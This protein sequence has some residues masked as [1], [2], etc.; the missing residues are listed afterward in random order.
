M[1][2][3]IVDGIL[4]LLRA[5]RHGNDGRILPKLVEIC[6]SE[7]CRTDADGLQDRR[8]RPV[9]PAFRLPIPIPTA[10]P[11]TAILESPP[12]AIGEPTYWV[13]PSFCPLAKR[14]LLLEVKL[15]NILSAGPPP[16]RRFVHIR[17]RR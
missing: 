4:L 11:G 12:N 9:R 6:I 16:S 10:V 1:T 14:W 5:K 13:N 17:I 8:H 15:Q 7:A 3:A 2:A